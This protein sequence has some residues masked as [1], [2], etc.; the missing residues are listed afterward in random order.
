MVDRLKKMRKGTQPV[1]YLPNWITPS[2]AGALANLPARKEPGRRRNINLLYSGNI[3]A[4]Q[5]LLR[6]CQAL[7]ESDARFAMR[8][9]G[10][11]ALA[12][13]VRRWV[14][15]TVD[16]RFSFGPLSDESAYAAA[17]CETDLFVITEKPGSGGSFVP[18]KLI[19]A[20]AAGAPILAVADDT[21]PLAAEVRAAKAGLVFSW[22]TLR[23]VPAFL[24]RV[25]GT[26]A[27]L[28]EW[29]ANAR[30]RAAFYDRDPIV[31]AYAEALRAFAAGQ[32]V[33]QPPLN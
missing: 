17:L 7:H 32:P 15:A 20:L 23:E 9:Q 3:G 4:K 5:D 13:D 26:P 14:E 30:R 19:A 10:G 1:L 29:S 21:S 16:D 25:M 18:S 8:I 33:R 6:F 28:T 12:A 24:D 2:L 22:D 11:G 27:R 31:A